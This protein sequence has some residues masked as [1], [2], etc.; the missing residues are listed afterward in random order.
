MLFRTK[1][2]PATDDTGTLVEVSFDGG[3]VDRSIVLVAWD[4]GSNDAHKSAAQEIA[5]AFADDNRLVL[6]GFEWGRDSEGG[7]LFADFQHIW[8]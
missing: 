6:R 2:V 1:T 4:Y 5:Q 8:E 7:V 3:E